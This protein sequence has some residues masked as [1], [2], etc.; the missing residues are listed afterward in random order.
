MPSLSNKLRGYRRGHRAESL[1]ALW[2]QLK[3]Y[4]ILARRF[5]TP[6]GEID[7]IARRGKQL[8]F[9]EVKGRD[10]AA[11]AAEAVHGRNQQRVVRAAQWWLTRHGQYI[12]HEV[13]FD[14][15]LIAWYRWP[16]HIPHAFHAS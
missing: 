1:A 5:K 12:E 8:I 10:N 4:R 11:T 14:V 7:L 3:G 15:V 9:V 13:R 6:L 16:H 2:L